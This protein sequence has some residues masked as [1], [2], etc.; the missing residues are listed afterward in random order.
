MK[1]LSLKGSQTD[2]GTIVNENEIEVKKGVIGMLDLRPRNMFRI[3]LNE[4]N[5]DFIRHNKMSPC[6]FGYSKFTI[7]ES[8]G[9]YNSKGHSI[10]S[11]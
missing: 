5:A 11:F 10:M 8:G 4:M 9:K 2:R 3:A 7:T 1:K 6:S